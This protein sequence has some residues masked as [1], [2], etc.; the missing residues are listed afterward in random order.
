ML[1]NLFSKTEDQKA[2]PKVVAD[3]K[4]NLSLGDKVGFF[5]EGELLGKSLLVAIEDTHLLFEALTPVDDLLNATEIAN[6]Q[7][8]I[9][10][11][12]KVPGLAEITEGHDSYIKCGVPSSIHIN[13]RRENFRVPIPISNNYEVGFFLDDKRFKARILDLS[14]TGAQIR[15]A[16]NSNFST[17]EQA[18]IHNAD[19]QLGDELKFAVQFHVRWVHY[20]SETARMGIEFDNLSTAESDA[21]HRVVNEVER[22]IIRKTKSLKP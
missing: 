14:S 9:P 15:V 10:W 16:S 17:A 21:I 3:L 8:G 2:D 4:R 6:I 1:K 13:S 19:I 18:L 7:R 11:D 20:L 22:E 5:H 12:F